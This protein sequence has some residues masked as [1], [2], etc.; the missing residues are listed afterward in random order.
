MERY[1]VEQ[2]KSG[3]ALFSADSGVPLIESGTK[4]EILW[5]TSKFLEG[6]CIVLRTPGSGNIQMNKTL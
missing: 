2:T 6:K 3:W 5:K 1:R 4:E